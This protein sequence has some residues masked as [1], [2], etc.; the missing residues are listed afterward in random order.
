MALTAVATQGFEPFRL[1]AP[2]EVLYVPGDPG[3]TYTKGH[4]VVATA[5][6]GVLDVIAAD[7]VMVGVAQQTIVCPAAT[8]AFPFPLV[9]PLKGQIDADAD[10]LTLIPIR[11]C[12]PAG[13]QVYLVTFQN[14]LDDTVISYDAT[15]RYVALTTGAAADDYPNGA[16]AYIYEGTGAGQLNV[17][18]DYDHTGGTVEKMLVFH[19]PFAVAP[20]ATSKL[21]ILSGEAATNKGVGSFGRCAIGAAGKVDV[22]DGA[23]DGEFTVYCDWRELAGHLKNLRVPV[24][25]SAA[26]LMA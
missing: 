13:T 5:G 21:I 8:T 18:E 2:D 17:V 19:R 1:V 6:E 20:D 10:Q 3:D 12:V 26:L 22:N 9:S 25:K 11:P 15:G 4:G 7:E 23:N 14:H 16:L 24:V